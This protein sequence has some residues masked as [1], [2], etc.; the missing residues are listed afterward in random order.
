MRKNPYYSGPPSDHFDGT[1]FFNPQGVPPG[2]VS[3]LLKWR[4][5]NKPDPWPKQWPSP[6]HGNK[7]PLKGTDDRITL[8]MIGHATML[9]QVAGQ[10]IITDPVYS[11]RVSPLSFAGPARVNPPGVEFDALP[12]INTILLSH[13]HYDHMDIATLRKLVERDN[14]L[15]VTPLGN[16]TILSRAGISARTIIGDWGDAHDVASDI[17]V[18]FEPAHHWSARGIRDRRMALWAAFVIDTPLGRIYHVGDTGFHEGRNFRT[19]G[20]KHGGFRLAIL[21]VGAYEPRWFMK[22]QHMNPEEAVLGMKLCGAEYAAG[23][24]WGTFRLTDEAIT[25]PAKD[26]AR[27]C[28]KHH[29]AADRFRPLLPGEQMIV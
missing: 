27:A 16:D 10:N 23:H 8:T 21:P 24:H 20:E 13:N 22:G 12:P 14:P 11:K 25:A 28:E 4:F 2:N 19:A 7:P 15:V 3:D 26:L 5:A 1:A 9:L 6:H 17:K 29:V 18:H